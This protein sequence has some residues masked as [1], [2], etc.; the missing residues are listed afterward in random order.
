MRVPTPLIVVAIVLALSALVPD[1]ISR[2]FVYKHRLLAP[3]RRS[4]CPACGR[5]LGIAALH[6]ADEH[7]RAHVAELH[8]AHPGARLRLIRLVQATCVSC[9]AMLSFREDSGTFRRTEAL[10]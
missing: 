3:A 2:H 4:P 7:W 6:E 5:T 9:G 1:A 10:A 8:R